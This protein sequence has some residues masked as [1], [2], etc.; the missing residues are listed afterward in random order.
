MGKGKEEMI[1]VSIIIPVYNAEKYIEECLDSL[2]RQTYPNFEI[3]CVDDGSQDRSLEILREY[4]EQDSRISVLTQNNQ[5]AGVA[6]NVGMEQAKGKYLLFLDADDFFCEDMLEQAVREAEKNGTEILVFDAYRYDE[7]RKEVKAESWTALSAD[8]FGDGVKTAVEIADVIYQFTTPSPWNKLFLKEY[9]EKN[10][11]RF[12]E[13]KRANDLFFTFAALSCA[14][15]IG[16]LRRKLMYYRICNAQS[17]QGSADD[18]PAVFALAAYAL[19]DFLQRRKLWET[20]NTGFYDMA[21][22]LCMNNLG[23]MK[24]EAAYVYL[25]EKLRDDVLP[26]L[27]IEMDRPDRRLAEAIRNRERI[28]VYGAGMLA[29]VLIRMLITKCGYEREQL[30]IAV[31]SKTSNTSQLCGVS[32]QEMQGIPDEERGHLVVIAISKESI[33]NEVEAASQAEGFEN[34]LKLGFKE[35]LSL[36]KYGVEAEMQ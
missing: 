35:M 11:L 4:E 15:R 20:F 17:L 5:Y 2:L 18:T 26:R 16:V 10:A 24:S 6:R 23:N 30:L 36:I 28:I 1:A 22:I 14:E 21:V 19:Q 9:V 29:S 27:E 12:Q 33:Q 8:L 32:V 3:I 25:F 31:S 13:I 7:L 34:I